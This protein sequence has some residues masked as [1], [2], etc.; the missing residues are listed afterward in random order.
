VHA[1]TPKTGAPW[2][3]RR[4]AIIVAME[5]E[6]APL[7]RKW[8]RAGKKVE[9]WD[10]PGHAAAKSS[11]RC[12]GVLILCAGI[13]RKPAAMAAR[14]ALDYYEPDLMISAGLAG[15]LNQQLAIGKVLRPAQVIDA[16][17][18]ERYETVRDVAARGVLVTAAS[19][20][21]RKAKEQ[22]AQQFGADAVDMEAAVVAEIARAAGVPF[23]AVKA[24]SDTLDFEMPPMDQ[25]IDSNG[26]LNL[27]KLIGW[28]SVRPNVWPVLGALRRNGKVAAEVLAGELEK[29]I[30]GCGVSSAS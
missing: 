21:S 22:M 16:A 2:G 5:M 7:L 26:R 9:H 27:L 29:T 12:D 14:A 8:K 4:V 10:G 28:A 11:Y 6:V 13:G 19:V 15:A 25:F 18:G 20:L 24:I 1:T 3:P 23:L 17:A 30:A